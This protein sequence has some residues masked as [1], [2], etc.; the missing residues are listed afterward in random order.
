MIIDNFK[1][2]GNTVYVIAEIGNNHNGSLKKAIELIDIAKDCGADC[3]KFQMRNLDELYRKQSLQSKGED[4]GSEYII[5][6]IRKFELTKDDHRTLHKYSRDKN[7]S[8]LCTPWD[9][10][11]INILQ[12]FQVPAFKIA[13]AD[14]NNSP[15]IDLLVETRKPLIFSTGMATEKDVLWLVNKL[16]NNKF[17]TEYALL[18]CNSTYPAPFH[19]INLRWLLKLKKIHSLIGYSGHERGIN[20]SIGAVALGAKIIERHLTLDRNLEGPDHAASLEPD[21]FRNLIIGIRELSESLGSYEN[22]HISQGEMINRENLGK[23]LVASKK[24]KKG[25]LILKNDVHVKSPGQGLSPIFFEKLISKILV[26][27]LEEGDFFFKSDLENKKISARNYKFKMRW[28]LPVRYHDF[29][30]L[31]AKIS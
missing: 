20:V 24:L 10:P 22:R 18:H 31:F 21:D 4:L 6:L 13:S 25:H 9:I 17:K 14:L 19:D 15:L 28:G 3:V 16:N 2:G 1:I 26:R 8:Y 7:I 30:K 11:S 29:D 5:D 23:S 12:D 27:D